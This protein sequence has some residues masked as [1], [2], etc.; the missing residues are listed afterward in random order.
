MMLKLNI[1]KLHQN[2]NYLFDHVEYKLNQ[3]KLTMNMNHL[4]VFLLI[5]I[6]ENVDLMKK[7]MKTMNSIHLNQ[8][9]IKSQLN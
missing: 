4:Q 8:S 9:I 5:V 6:D 7:L 2:L 1:M 3:I